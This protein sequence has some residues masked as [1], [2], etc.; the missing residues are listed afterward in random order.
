[1][2]PRTT[3]ETVDGETPARLATS[4]SVGRALRSDL[5]IAFSCGSQR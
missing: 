2:E 1:V 5:L 4:S 3:R